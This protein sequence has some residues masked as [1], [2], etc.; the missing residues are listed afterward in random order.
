MYVYVYHR[1]HVRVS[2]HAYTPTIPHV[3]SVQSRT[4]YFLLTL[5]HTRP[6]LPTFLPHFRAHTHTHAH[7][8]THTHTHTHTHTQNSITLAICTI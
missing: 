6:T 1:T 4:S 5:P 7:A 8:Y 3:Q 2:F